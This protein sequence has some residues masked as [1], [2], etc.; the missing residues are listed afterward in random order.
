EIPVN[1]D[2]YNTVNLNITF[3]GQQATA[4]IAEPDELN[5]DILSV[6]LNSAGSTT[7]SGVLYEWSGPNGFE[8]NEQNPEVTDPGVYTLTVSTA[9]LC[10]AQA[11]V[12]VI[13]DF[14]PPEISVEAEGQFNCL[15][16]TVT[17]TGTSDKP[18][19]TY[20]WSG[21]PNLNVNTPTAT[22]TQ[23]GTF[24]FLVTT[25]AGCTASEQ[26]VLEADYE[27]P[28]ISTEVNGIID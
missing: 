6:I 24:T 8:S 26:I 9:A 19:V 23:P 12:E 20:N 17:L 18:N 3:G 21:P 1:E 28:D 5:C 7:G 15:N 16:Q 22:A 25:A 10:P 4:V 27:T 2:C 14:N 11:S 13:M